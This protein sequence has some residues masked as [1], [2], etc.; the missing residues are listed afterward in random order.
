MF[1]EAGSIFNTPPTLVV[2]LLLLYQYTPEA[3]NSVSSKERLA[4]AYTAALVAVVG[5]STLPV[6]SRTAPAPVTV[7]P[8]RELGAKNVAGVDV[9][10][11]LPSVMLSVP[12]DTVLADELAE[13]DVAPYDMELPLDH[14]KLFVIVVVNVIACGNNREVSVRDVIGVVV[15]P[16]NPTAVP[17]VC[18]SVVSAA[19]VV[20][21]STVQRAQSLTALVNVI[22]PYTVLLFAMT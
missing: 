14:V 12:K 19:K 7:S 17:E 1:G 4:L 15:C 8:T 6:L 11:M 2:N 20:R 9:V 21:P 5:T 16:V 18:V 3:L 22:E 13:K 10:V